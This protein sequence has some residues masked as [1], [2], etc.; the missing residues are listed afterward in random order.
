M[1]ELIDLIKQ[2]RERTG[3]GIM[4][5]K[6]ALLANDSD[7]E[8]SVVWL[9]EKG[10]AKQASKANRVAA[11]GV[12]WV[13]TEGNKAAVIEINCETDFVANSDPFRNLVK[14][15][16]QIVL[17]NSPKD[18]DAALLCKSKNGKDIKELFLEAGIKLGE[19]L[20]FRRFAIVTKTD[21]EVFG[22]YIHMNGKIA[23]L[24]VLKGGNT[25]VANGVALNVCSN[26]PLY[27]TDKDIPADDFAKEVEIE[28]EASKNDPSFAKKPAAI[29]QKIIEGRVHKNL[30]GNVL[31]DEQYV[32]DESKTVSDVL[33]ENKAAV[34]SYVRFAVGEGIEKRH[35]DFAAEVANQVK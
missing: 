6:K 21:D 27:L 7:I 34:A 18:K 9:R 5:C 31:L 23:T 13:L 28:K 26:N 2:L 1:S 20:D 17:E 29:Q 4:D 15:V 32:L 12:A 25:E 30:C 35:D 19:K 14:E 8:K 24:V 11:E 33:K 10:I 22:P 16:N 3:A